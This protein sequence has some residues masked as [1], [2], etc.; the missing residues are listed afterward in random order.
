MYQLTFSTRELTGSSPPCLLQVYDTGGLRL[1]WH[2]MTT[3]R[4]KA[5]DR[6]MTDRWVC[7]KSTRSAESTPAIWPYTISLTF[8]T[9]L[10]FGFT[11]H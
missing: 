5:T 7:S 6:V 8:F 9:L 1:M 4:P 3:P 11:L 2:S 10:D